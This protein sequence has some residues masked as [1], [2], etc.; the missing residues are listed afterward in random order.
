MRD[1]IIRFDNQSIDDF[2]AKFRGFYETGADS[3]SNIVGVQ[4]SVVGHIINSDGHSL[5]ADVVILVIFGEVLFN[6]VISLKFYLLVT[7]FK[8]IVE[9]LLDNCWINS[10]GEFLLSN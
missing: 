10:F 4:F 8:A 6:Q 3:L 5:T 2:F 9:A 7:G 1:G